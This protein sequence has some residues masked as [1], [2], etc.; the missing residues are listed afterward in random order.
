M[1]AVTLDS[2]HRN[3]GQILHQ[4]ADVLMLMLPGDHAK[5]GICQLIG[6]FTPQNPLAADLCSWVLIF[7]ICLLQ[8]LLL[9]TW[10]ALWW[11]KY[12]EFH[13]PGSTNM[14]VASP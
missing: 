1:K 6:L 2:F 5:H 10:E 12:L 9:D 13:L 4:E 8:P 7:H 3:K 11:S 14:L